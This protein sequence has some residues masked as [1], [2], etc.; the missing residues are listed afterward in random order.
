MRAAVL[1]EGLPFGSVEGEEHQ[2]FQPCLNCSKPCV[3]ACP[4]HVF[5]GMGSVDLRACADNRHA[6]EC[7]H[8]CDARRACPVGAAERYGEEEERFRHAYSLFTMR[9][10]FGL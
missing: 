6:G 1:V 8:G 9:R 5:D 10:H 2:P 3:K 4:V 7:G